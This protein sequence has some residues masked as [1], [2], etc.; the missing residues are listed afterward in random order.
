MVAL[1]D[2]ESLAEK[3]SLVESLGLFGFEAAVEVSEQDLRSCRMKVK[4]SHV[5]IRRRSLGEHSVA[6][7]NDQLQ[8]PLV[9]RISICG[10]FLEFLFGSALQ[11]LIKARERDLDRLVKGSHQMDASNSPRTAFGNL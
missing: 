1:Q 10:G 5:K 11:A 3:M 9:P 6:H 7:V 2:A 8:D 4:D